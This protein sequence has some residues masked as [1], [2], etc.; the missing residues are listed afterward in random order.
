[1]DLQVVAIV[2]GWLTVLFAFVQ[3]ISF[4]NNTVFVDRTKYKTSGTNPAVKVEE[5]TAS[6]NNVKMTGRRNQKWTFNVSFE[7]A[8]EH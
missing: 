6:L 8:E 5:V 1:M 7:K 3:G 2:F 4:P